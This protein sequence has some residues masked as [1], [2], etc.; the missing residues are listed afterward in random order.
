MNMEWALSSN[1]RPARIGKCKVCAGYTANL[2][3]LVSR[4][5]SE[6]AVYLTK[7]CEL[8]SSAGFS[9]S[10][11]T[12]MGQL[13]ME[14]FAPAPFPDDVPTIDL[15]K[16]SL[17]K[18]LNNDEF[19]ARKMFEICASTGFFYLNMMDHPKGRN[20]WEDACHACRVGKQVLPNHSIEEKQ[21]YKTRDRFGIFDKG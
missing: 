19:E 20:L 12:Y 6:V 3:S 11:I 8:G 14:D 15:E 2:N 4:N 7:Y 10:N 13:D 21:T 5:R 18:L 1:S 9:C 17:N 16:I